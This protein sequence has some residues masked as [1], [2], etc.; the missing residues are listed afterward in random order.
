[1]QCSCLPV[2]RCRHERATTTAESSCNQPWVANIGQDLDSS[3]TDPL[4]VDVC[5][6]PKAHSLEFSSA[7]ATDLLT[8]P[9]LHKAV[10]PLEPCS[11]ASDKS[12]GLCR[13]MKDSKRSL[14][15]FIALEFAANK[16]SKSDPGQL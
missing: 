16:A 6:L 13:R 10:S 8:E 9:D 4:Q 7:C 12:R 2:S 3:D 11:A 5:R 15:C 14:P 1:M